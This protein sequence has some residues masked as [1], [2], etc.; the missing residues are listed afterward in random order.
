L[1]LTVKENCK[2]F[3]KIRR[4]KW[5]GTKIPLSEEA[6]AKKSEGS[7]ENRAEGSGGLEGEAKEREKAK[8]LFCSD[9]PDKQIYVL[10]LQAP[11]EGGGLEVGES[12]G[13]TQRE[14][15]WSKRTALLLGKV[16]RGAIHGMQT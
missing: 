6:A 16:D 13:G 7:S 11:N 14:E 8:T 1:F 4:W 10:S 3:E 15:H 9:R 2:P 5:P 12:I